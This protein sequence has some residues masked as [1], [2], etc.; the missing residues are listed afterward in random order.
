MS[1]NPHALA[2]R[3]FLLQVYKIICN[4]ILFISQFLSQAQILTSSQIWRASFS[5]VKSI[6]YNLH[7][8]ADSASEINRAANKYSD[9]C[10]GWGGEYSRRERAA[11]SSRKVQFVFLNKSWRGHESSACGWM[12]CR[13]CSFV[14]VILFHLHAAAHTGSP[15]YII[16]NMR[17]YYST[18][19]NMYTRSYMLFYPG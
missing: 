4:F 15:L 13:F 6:L 18:R 5:H 9:Y 7:R 14:P 10:Q 11:F 19:K 3:V 12:T 16:R 17:F 1:K 8:A 2:I